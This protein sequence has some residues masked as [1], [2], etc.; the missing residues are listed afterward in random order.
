MKHV[1]PLLFL[2]LLSA[3]SP[4]RE[5]YAAPSLYT[6]ITTG[7][8]YE[9]QEDMIL[10]EFDYLIVPLIKP[11]LQ[12]APLYGKTKSQIA[13]SKIVKGFAI[14]GYANKGDLL[15]VSGYQPQGV[16]IPHGG[17]VAKVN[18]MAVFIN[19]E[20]SGKAV[21]I[22]WLC[23]DGPERVSFRSGNISGKIFFARPDAISKKEG[24]TIRS[25]RSLRSCRS[26]QTDYGFIA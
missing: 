6:S 2:F 19:G 11:G 17:N 26:V 20:L 3:C 23:K 8:V 14:V 12:L 5:F 16:W 9:L 21:G 4:F 15:A 22:S 13:E 10:V 18:P 7:D 1:A 24:L 25:S